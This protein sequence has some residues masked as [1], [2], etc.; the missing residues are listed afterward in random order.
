[1]VLCLSRFVVLFVCFVLSVSRALCFLLCFCVFCVLFRF[2]LCFVSCLFCV[3]SRVL[4]CFLVLRLCFVFIYYGSLSAPRSVAFLAYVVRDVT[5]VLEPICAT[6][7]FF[8]DF[9]TQPYA[10][11]TPPLRKPRAS[12][13]ISRKRPKLRSRNLVRRYVAPLRVKRA[14]PRQNR[15]GG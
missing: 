3:A 8:L 14:R 13:A 9:S 12:T 4:F 6:S 10:G 5:L 15:P 7:S 1:M 11:D 2:C